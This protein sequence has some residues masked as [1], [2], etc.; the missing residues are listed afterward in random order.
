MTLALLNFSWALARNRFLAIL[1]VATVD[2]IV[3]SLRL[4]PKICHVIVFIE[5]LHGDK[6]VK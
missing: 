5:A 6:L 3:D 1:F 4:V 2:F